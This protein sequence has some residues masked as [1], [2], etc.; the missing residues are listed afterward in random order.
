VDK[1]EVDSSFN[2]TEGEC[3]EL[4]IQKKSSEKKFDSN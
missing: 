1:I 3:E 2:G 4:E